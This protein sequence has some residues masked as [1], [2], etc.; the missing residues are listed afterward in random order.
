ME[1]SLESEIYAP[2]VNDQG[3]YVDKIPPV[4]MHGIRCPCS[5]RRDKVYPNK[6]TFSAH[7]KTKTH[8]KWM[9]EMN[10]NRS[11]YFVDNVKLN[12][13]IKQ[14]ENIKNKYLADIDTLKNTKNK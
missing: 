7:I 3:I 6:Q 14:E 5:N 10:H 4:I 2:I 1:L 13:T 8:V 11:N 9:E 12:E